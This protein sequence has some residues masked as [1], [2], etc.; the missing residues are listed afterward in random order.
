MSQENV[1]IVKRIYSEWERGNFF[2]LPELFDAS[3]R[4]T[5]IDPL[6]ARQSETLGLGETTRNMRDWLDTYDG[7]SAKAEAF[8]D[9]GEGRVVVIAM[10]SGRGKASGVEMAERLGTVFTVSGGRVT[11]LVQHRDPSEALEAAG[12]RE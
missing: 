2:A 7:M 6:L 5:W 4:A 3:L 10:W 11:R 9:A 12:L 8:H 1:E